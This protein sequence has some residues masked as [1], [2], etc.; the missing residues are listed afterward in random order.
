MKKFEY[1]TTKIVSPG[2]D[3]D[4]CIERLNRLGQE[5]WEIVAAEFIGDSMYRFFFK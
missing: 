1:Y 2:H 4:S 3:H 5:G